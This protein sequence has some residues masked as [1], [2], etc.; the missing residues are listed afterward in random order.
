MWFAAEPILA[1]LAPRGIG[2]DPHRDQLAAWHQISGATHL[3]RL[4]PQHNAMLRGRGIELDV[5]LD[6]PTRRHPDRAGAHL[7]L[8]SPHFV[9]EG[10]A[11]EAYYLDGNAPNGARAI[12][13]SEVHAEVRIRRGIDETPKL[14]AV[15][16]KADSGTRPAGCPASR[17]E[18]PLTLR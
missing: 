9:G 1:R 10:H 5:E 15:G 17:I 18:I 8:P 4:G 16:R 14:F 12:D 13:I 2:I 11:I 6:A 3:D 7:R